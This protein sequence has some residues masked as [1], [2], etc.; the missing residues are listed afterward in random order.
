MC[1]LVSTDELAELWTPS[2]AF[3]QLGSGEVSRTSSRM[4]SV[5]SPFQDTSQQHTPVPSGSQP[6]FKY[7]PTASVEVDKSAVRG[8]QDS[9]AHSGTSSPI[10]QYN[11]QSCPSSAKSS[12]RTRLANIFGRWSMKE[13]SIPTA[14]SGKEI[15]SQSEE[16]H[17]EKDRIKEQ[18]FLRSLQLPL[19]SPTHASRQSSSSSEDWPSHEL[20]SLHERTS[21]LTRAS[22]STD[23]TIT[24]SLLL[25]Q[26]K[27]QELAECEEVDSSTLQ[28]DEDG[29]DKMPQNLPHKIAAP[30][31]NNASPELPSCL[32]SRS[33]LSSKR[34]RCNTR[35]T[36]SV[37]S[38]SP[39]AILEQYVNC[40]LLIHSGKEAISLTDMEGIDWNHYGGCPHSEELGV[41]TAYVAMLQSQ[42]MFE[43]YQCQQHSRRNRR[44]LSKARTASKLENE[45]VTLVSRKVSFFLFYQLFLQRDQL[46]QQNHHISVLEQELELSKGNAT[47][48]T[49]SLVRENT[50]LRISNRALR[51]NVTCYQKQVDELTDVV[52]RL[53]QVSSGGYLNHAHL[54]LALHRN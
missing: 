35:I 33:V 21:T 16:F 3:S 52:E 10:R 1:G 19:D 13:S 53:Q 39:A 46:H 29:K 8:L 26:E 31:S 9:P 7:S 5:S 36:S 37:S 15:F 43:R 14:E 50:A 4:T 12:F 28:V 32:L 51:E 41:M 22:F 47:S 44:L 20:I 48:M 24:S 54:L 34:Q 30:V 42:V 45:I 6:T 27:L 17:R 18:E 49:D 11:S 23:D 25:A 2:L 40:G 38:S